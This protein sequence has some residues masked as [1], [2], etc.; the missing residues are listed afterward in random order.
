MT[1]Q[2]DPENNETK[3]LFEI[4]GGF[5]NKRV[6]E[7]GCGDGRL[8]WR[9]AYH[10]AQV[11]ALDPDAD[12]IALAREDIPPG[13]RGRVEFHTGELQEYKAFTRGRKF[14]TALLSWSL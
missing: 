11:T 3:A 10:A 12:M 7:I 1:I 14:D 4:S 2:L 5:E 13:L 8:T 9:Y 6:F